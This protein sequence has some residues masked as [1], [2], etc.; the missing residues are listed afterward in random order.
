MIPTQYYKIIAVTKHFNVTSC[1]HCGRTIINVATV[2]GANGNTYYIGE[3]CARTL[4]EAHQRE[5]KRKL[6]LNLF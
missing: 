4:T 5:T 6:Q 3:G 1:Q 2:Q